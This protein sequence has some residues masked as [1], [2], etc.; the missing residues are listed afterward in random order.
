MNNDFPEFKLKTEF[1]L[2]KV[3]LTA[4]GELVIAKVENKLA[5]KTSTEINHWELAQWIA[6]KNWL[7]KYKPKPNASNLDQVKGYLQAF[8]HLCELEEW[9]AAYKILFIKINS[10][11]KEELYDQLDTWGY[12]QELIDLYNRIL[13]KLS[14]ELD[15][16]FFRGLGRCYYLLSKYHQAIEYYQKSLDLA[17][18]LGNRANE[19]KALRGLGATYN[20][21]GNYNEAILYLEDSFKIAQEIDNRYLEGSCL[22]VFGLVY[23]NLGNYAKAIEYQQ[24]C[25]RIA[26]ELDDP[27]MESCT[28]NRLGNIFYL[29]GNHREGLSYFQQALTIVQKIGDRSLEG[30]VLFSFGATY[31]SLG[32][33]HQAISYFNQV[34]V[35]AAEIGDLDLKGRGMGGLGHAYRF[36]GN[37]QQAIDYHQKNLDIVRLTGNRFGEIT[38]LLSLGIVFNELKDYHQAINLLE[39]GLAIAQKLGTCV[40]EGNALQNLGSVY[41]SLKDYHQAISYFNQS[42]GIAKEVGDQE[43]EAINLICLGNAYCECENYSQ[44][45]EYYQKSLNIARTIGDIKTEELALKNL[46]KLALVQKNSTNFTLSLDNN[47]DQ[48]RFNKMT[49]FPDFDVKI[50]LQLEGVDLTAPGELVIAK[51][52]NKLAV[53]TSTEINH[54]ELAQWIA[55][56]TWLTKYKPKP[57]ASNLDQVKG[58]LQAF[59]HLCELEEWEAA[60]KIL[61]I[62]IN[63][64][65][66]EELYEQLTTWALYQESFELYNRIVDRLNPK[67]NAIILKLLG[68]SHFYLGNYD[69]AKDYFEKS[70]VIVQTPANQDR[71]QEARLLANLGTIYIKQRVYD[72]ALEYQ[73]Q[74][75]AV[76]REIKD[77]HWEAYALSFL[78]IIE[79]D[80]GNYNQGINYYQQS[81]DIFQ[82][83]EDSIGEVGELCHVGLAY[84]ELGDYNNAINYLQQALDMGNKMQYRVVQGVALMKLGRAYFRLREQEKAIEYLEESLVILEGIGDCANLIEGVRELGE[85]YFSLGKYAEAKDFYQK[86]LTIAITIKSLLDQAW[87]CVCLG[88]TYNAL[89]DYNKGFEYLQPVLNIVPE[90]NTTQLNK[91]WLECRTKSNLATS[92]YGLADFTKAIDYYQETLV[93]AKEIKDFPS[94]Y[95]CLTNIGSIYTINLGEPNKSFEY[96]EQGIIIAKE[97]KDHHQEFTFLGYLGNAYYAFKDFKKSDFYYQESLKLAKE[98]P[99]SRLEGM[100]LDSLGNFYYSLNNFIEAIDYYQQYLL[101]VQSDEDYVN[102]AITLANLG[103]AY[104]SLKDYTKAIDYHC[105]SL[106]IAKRINNRTLIADFTSNLGNAYLDIKDYDLSIQYYEEF[107][108]IQSELANLRG[109]TNALLFLVYVYTILEQFQK[110]TYYLELLQEI[111]KTTNDKQAKD[112][113]IQ[114]INKILPTI[115]EIYLDNHRYQQAIT[116]HRKML[117]ISQDVSDTAMESLAVAWLGCDFREMGQLQTAIEWLK[118]RLTLAETLNDCNAQCETLN[119]LGNTYK[120]LAEQEQAIQYYEEAITNYDKAIALNPD[121]PDYWS[122]RGLILQDLGYYQEAIESYQQSAHAHSAE[123]AYY[124]VVKC[125]ERSLAIAREINDELWIGK[126][127]Y[128]LADTL[129]QPTYYAKK[130]EYSLKALEHLQEAVEIFR[131]LSEPINEAN[132][133]KSLADLS[134]KLGFRD[135]AEQFCAQALSIATQLNIISIQEDCQKLKKQW[136]L[137]EIYA[138]VKKAKKLANESETNQ[139]LQKAYRLCWEAELYSELIVVREQIKNISEQYFNEEKYLEA[140]QLS[141]SHL[142]LLNELTA[143]TNCEQ[144]VI[145]LKEDFYWGWYSK[146][147]ALRQLKRYEE[148]LVSFDKAIKIKSDDADCWKDRGFTLLNLALYEAGLFHFPKLGTQF[149]S[150]IFAE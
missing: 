19:A 72:K 115:G 103:K 62:K 135:L 39:E 5:V 9:E 63:S 148:A 90:L 29:R 1:Q 66:K 70:L 123:K 136:L 36:L 106:A 67:E 128:N 134:Y 93:I 76:A 26:R 41:L 82:Q 85:I 20:S 147:N 92:Y 59:Q 74:S 54:W 68:N 130:R 114:T 7:T 23:Q 64:P 53:K 30:Y 57:N 31:S 119:W 45:T 48:T 78:G 88:A 98:I 127:L 81:L 143:N 131:K 61:F 99:D 42:L 24:Q 86:G 12:P 43:L 118:K 79:T 25:L 40:S 120:N 133:L 149:D 47:S 33:Y 104:S 140:F 71:H 107:L 122:N 77:S 18:E 38:A 55:V 91:C 13:G 46:E 6:I 116:I 117:A 139:A 144:K 15:V 37:Y 80:F 17:R 141:E 32:D 21:L 58:Y 10:P 105:Q 75:L 97:F 109:Q 3:D 150:P 94:L 112:S 121:N 52:E 126:I 14:P 83:L 60:Y 146:G 137:Q 132:A 102:E 8:Q 142:F 73:H 124:Q 28:L 125:H 56:K 4:P 69:Q 44:A 49:D 145:D 110:V 84:L 111:F 22:G 2:E 129:L 51:V 100:A 50:E 89:G 65:T 113:A 108:T 96:Y 16:F 138:E 87:L 35:I 101:L 11:T 34:L 27:F 95:S